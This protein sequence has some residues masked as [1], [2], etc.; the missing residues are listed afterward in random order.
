MFFIFVF[1]FFLFCV[2]KVRLLGSG[3]IINYAL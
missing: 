1:L 2:R 3:C